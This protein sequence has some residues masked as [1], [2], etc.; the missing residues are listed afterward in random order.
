MGPEDLRAL[1]LFDGLSDEQLAQLAEAGSEVVVEPG[2]ELFH[3][4]DHADSWWVLV[5]GAVELVRRVGREDV[6]VGRMDVPGR[7]AGGFRAWDEHGVYLASA[8][9]ATAAR[10]LQVPAAALGELA[11][12][13]FPFG[14]HLVRGLYGTA[15]TIEATVRQRAS[16]VALGELAAGF[17]HEINN[18]AAAAVRAVDGLDAASQALVAS[19]ARLVERGISAPQFAALDALRREV[20]GPRAGSDPLRVSEDEDAV[21]AWLDRRGVARAW[22]LAPALAAAGVDVQ[23]C[24][25]AAGVLPGAV[26]EP[27][28]EWV[29]SSLDVASLL[30]DVGESTRRI[31]TLVAAVRSYSQMDRGSLQLVDIT[32]GLESTLVMLGHKLGNRVDVVRSYAPDVPRVQAYAG[33]LNQVWTNLMDNALDAMDGAGVLGVATRGD[34]G[35]VVVEISDTGPGMSAEVAERAFEPFYTTKAG[36]QRTG[37]G[38]DIARRIVVERHGGE[39]GIDSRPGLTLVRVRIPARPSV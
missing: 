39:M 27:G 31:S 10:L 20:P 36:G 13:W 35:G 2:K 34:D 9:V 12:V 33:E 38:L 5:E 25:R 23:W 30:S 3:E 6:V 32:D 16:L 29:A 1:A 8:R 4:G 18:P 14:A 15:R 26:L 11:D 37:L 21:E 28:M 22:S 17:A 24:E 7:W 19:L